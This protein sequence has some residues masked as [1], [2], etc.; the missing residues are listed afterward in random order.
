MPLHTLA[1]GHGVLFVTG[2]WRQPPTGSHVSIV[3]TLPS[4]QFGGTAAVQ[5]PATHVSAPLHGFRSAQLVPFD[6]GPFAQPVVWL[7]LSVVHGF[8]SSQAG[9]W[10]QPSVG[11]HAS[12]V[13]ASLSAHDMNVPGLHEP[14]RQLS[15][16]VQRLP[17]LQPNVFGTWM[18]PAIGSQL[19][20]VHELPS[21]QVSS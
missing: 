19:S 3:Q 17:S 11:P 13:H 18:H 12:S 8:R 10:T 16:T 20:V 4:S 2:T 1:S 21:L 9:R 7:Q 6:A 5:E 14:F 15:L